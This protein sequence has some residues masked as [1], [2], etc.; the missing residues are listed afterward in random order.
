MKLTISLLH[1]DSDDNWPCSRTEFY[2][3]HVER[4]SVPSIF[5]KCSFFVVDPG[6]FVS[7]VSLFPVYKYFVKVSQFSEY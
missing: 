7:F 1:G 3:S 5:L 4:F 6:F 2:N